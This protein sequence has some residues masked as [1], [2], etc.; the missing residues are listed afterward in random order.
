MNRDWW[1]RHENTISK[2]AV[3]ALVLLIFVMV[4]FG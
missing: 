3:A 1:D 4:V 2:L